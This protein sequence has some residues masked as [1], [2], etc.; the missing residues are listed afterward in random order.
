MLVHPFP[1]SYLVITRLI[2]LHRR[3]YHKA[4]TVPGKHLDQVWRMYEEFERRSSNAQLARREVDEQRPRYQAAKAAA[5]ERA[6]HLDRLQLQALALPPGET[7]P[8]LTFVPLIF[9]VL[10]QFA[11]HCVCKMRFVLGFSF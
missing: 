6:R 4:L 11:R 5:T 7:H 8:T 1:W 3:A 10:K 2:A 9:V